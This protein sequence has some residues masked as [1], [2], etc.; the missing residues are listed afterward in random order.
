MA[1]QS[2]GQITL[3]EIHVEAGGSSGSQVALSDV[4]VKDLVGADNNNTAF[5]DYYGATAANTTSSRVGGGATTTNQFPNANA[6]LSTGN[7]LVVII[8]MYRVQ[9]GSAISNAPT[10]VTVGGQSATQHVI[11]NQN[12]ASLS[13]GHINSIWVLETTLSGTQLVTGSTA[14]GTGNNSCEV[15]EITGH[16]S[17][18]PHATSSSSNY[19]GTAGTTM[20]LGNISTVSGGTLLMGITAT[21]T[22]NSSAIS[23]NPSTTVQDVVFSNLNHASARLDGTSAGSNAFTVTNTQSGFFNVVTASFK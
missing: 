18:T 12:V 19:T 7:K 22:G 4:D 3:N 17:A 8:P 20:S 11:S 6:T 13:Y 15:Y 9:S 21:A 10:S 2:S 1:L 23:T 16:T 14:T 5:S